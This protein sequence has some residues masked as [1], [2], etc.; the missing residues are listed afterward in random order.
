MSVTLA[1]NLVAMA[2][3][4]EIVWTRPVHS[5]ILEGVYEGQPLGIL[6]RDAL[7]QVGFG[8]S[9]DE[10]AERMVD[11]MLSAHNVAFNPSISRRAAVVGQQFAQRALSTL[12]GVEEPILRTLVSQYQLGV[13]DE[14]AVAQ[15][16]DRTLGQARSITNTAIAGVQRAAAREVSRTVADGPEIYFLYAG[17]DDQRIRPYCAA[18]VGKAVQENLLANT[19]NGTGLP[20][21]IYCGGWNCRHTLIPTNLRII[22]ADSIPIASLADYAKARAGGKPK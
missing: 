10:A 22:A 3:R 6:L 17:P 14:K 12:V 8:V 7:V 13:V 20:P 15:A 2:A 9:V 4:A 1:R 5:T 11:A 19:P 18:L 16:L 21:L